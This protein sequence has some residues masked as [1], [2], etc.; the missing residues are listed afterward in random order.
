MR[1]FNKYLVTAILVSLLASP[2]LG[3][4]TL[5]QCIKRALEANFSVIIS[6]NNLQ[7]A[8]NNVTL[9]PFLPS[10]T[11]SSRQS[12]NRLEQRNYTD[13]GARESSRSTGSAI[14]NS[15]NLSWKLFDGF[16]M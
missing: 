3:Q 8:K 16:S 2:A 14:L 12:A 11:L 15:A 1:I 9:A 6:D 4:V 7:I 5:E 10:V 13:E